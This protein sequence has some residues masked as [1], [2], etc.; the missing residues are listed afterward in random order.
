[1]HARQALYQEVLSAA[2]DFLPGKGP[3]SVVPLQ[4]ALDYLDVSQLKR[5]QNILNGLGVENPDWLP[6]PHSAK[7]LSADCCHAQSP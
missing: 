2:P 3:S 7:L 1:M 6:F 4:I 5:Q